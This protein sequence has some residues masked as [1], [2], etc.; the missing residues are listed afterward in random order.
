MQSP[1]KKQKQKR[2]VVVRNS[3]FGV[4]VVLCLSVFLRVCLFV[5]FRVC[6]CVRFAFVYVICLVVK[7]WFVTCFLENKLD[8]SYRKDVRYPSWPLPQNL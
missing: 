5:C 8:V 7:F 6:L 4:V 1:S 3:C 2:P